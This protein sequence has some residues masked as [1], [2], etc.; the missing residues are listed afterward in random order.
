M[1]WCTVANQARADAALASVPNADAAVVGDPS[2]IRSMR[3]V[4]D[5]VNALALFDAVIHNAGIGYHRSVS[6][7]LMT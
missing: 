4:A 3:S 7:H 6:P 5:Q 2:N 1:S